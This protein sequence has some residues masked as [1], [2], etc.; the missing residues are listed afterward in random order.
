M[1]VVW[2]PKPS[3]IGKGLNHRKAKLFMFG[4]CVFHR[5]TQY[6]SF[7]TSNIEFPDFPELWVY[8]RMFILSVGEVIIH[9]IAF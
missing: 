7:Q 9:S 2:F 1:R 6:F 8:R 5:D 3:T 4:E